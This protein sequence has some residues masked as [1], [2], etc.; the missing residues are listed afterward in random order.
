MPNM[1]GLNPKRSKIKLLVIAEIA[2]EFVKV[3]HDKVERVVAEASPTFK[4]L[5]NM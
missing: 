5:Y 4:T 3:P 1:R 2:V